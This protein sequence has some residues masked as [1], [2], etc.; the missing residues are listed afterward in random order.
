MHLIPLPRQIHSIGMESFT[1]Q[2]IRLIRSHTDDTLPAEQLSRE[3]LRVGVT[4][5]CRNEN[6][7]TASPLRFLLDASLAR[8]EY[9]ID[10]SRDHIDLRGGAAPALYYA[11]QTLRQIIRQQGDTL[12]CLRI[13]DQPDYPVRGFYHD[14][15]RGKVPKIETLFALIERLAHLKINHF[16]LYIEHPF[17]FRRHPEIWAGSDPLT[18]ENIRALEAHCRRHHIDF[19]PSLSTFGH[20][21]R[22][23]RNQRNQHLNELPCD[24][25]ERPFSFR[26]AMTHYTLDCRNPES[27]RLMEELIR[28]Y[29][30]LFPSPFFNICCDETFDLGKGKN[31][32]EALREGTASLYTEYLNALIAKV[33]HLHKTPLFWSDVV[34]HHREALPAVSADSILLHWDYAPSPSEKECRYL[35]EVG[36]PYYVCSGANGW[37]K[38]FN[39]IP[40]AS[41]NILRLARLGKQYDAVGFINTDW[42]DIGHINFLSSSFHAIALG[43]AC[44]WQV[45]P[46]EKTEA[47]C[48]EEM[49]RAFAL[50]EFGDSSG[51]MTKLMRETAQ[52]QRITWGDVSMWRDPSPDVP[53]A[54]RDVQ[55][56]FPKSILSIPAVELTRAREDLRRV[57]DHL[58]TL[59]PDCTPQDDSAGDELLCSLQGVDLMLRIGLIMHAVNSSG[60]A[61]D[62]AETADQL[63]RL[64]NQLSVLWHRRNR[65]SEYYRLR[66][67]LLDAAE[68]LDALQTPIQKSE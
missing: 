8:E 59:L 58:N 50:L 39:D 11:A 23:I 44:A 12:P 47:Q 57:R 21:Y 7:P 62:A 17:A 63:R 37:R 42:G 45:P 32:A 41:L 34:L 2:R 29:A 13:H 38:C 64:E 27:L 52:C 30:E 49:D 65:P 56:G 16:Q 54:W 68:R 18:H 3:W 19:V 48:L 55:T 6:D 20:C 14:I 66:M 53:E 4:A 40:N 35:Q 24:A 26:D 43:A 1:A 25:T 5:S 36:R 67:D 31:A 9:D 15:S 61:P 51:G 28:E 10:I 60:A 33:H 46:P 22:L